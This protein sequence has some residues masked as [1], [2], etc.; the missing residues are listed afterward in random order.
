[1]A[2]PRVRQSQ[3][4]I[5]LI[6]SQEVLKDADDNILHEATEKT[7]ETVDDA[8]KNPE[9]D[10]IKWVDPTW[11][12]PMPNLIQV[13]ESGEYCKYIKKGTK[14]SLF[15]QRKDSDRKEELEG[16]ERIDAGIKQAALDIARGAPVTKIA[17]NE[18]KQE[19]LVGVLDKSRTQHNTQYIK[20]AFNKLELEDN[21]RDNIIS[22]FNQGGKT[23]TAFGFFTNMAN[24]SHQ[25]DFPNRPGV[26]IIEVDKNVTRDNFIF[27]KIDKN[28]VSFSFK[29]Y[30]NKVDAI[31]GSAGRFS[32]KPEKQPILTLT[33]SFNFIWDEEK[34]EMSVDKIEVGI[35]PGEDL[36]SYMEKTN[37]VDKNFPG[38]AEKLANPTM[39][40][41]EEDKNK[42]FDNKFNAF[43]GLAEE[44]IKE[45]KAKIE[46]IDPTGKKQELA[47]ALNSH[48]EHKGNNHKILVKFLATKPQIK[49]TLQ[50]LETIAKVK[51]F[52]TLMGKIDQVDS[53]AVFDM[54]TCKIGPKEIAAAFGDKNTIDQ[55]C[56]AK[57]NFLQK[58]V[59][60][61]LIF[62]GL[63][64]PES[65]H[66]QD[67]FGIASSNK[68][69]LDR[70]AEKVEQGQRGIEEAAL[71]L[72]A[73]KCQDKNLLGKMLKTQDLSK[74]SLIDKMQ[75]ALE[76]QSLG[77]LEIGTEKIL[78]SDKMN[79]DEK[80]EVLKTTLTNAIKIGDKGPLYRILTELGE[81]VNK[82]ESGEEDQPITQIL[83][84]LQNLSVEVYQDKNKET[85]VSEN[86]NQAREK[87]FLQNHSLLSKVDEKV[88]NLYST[89]KNRQ[90]VICTNQDAGSD[91]TKGSDQKN[92]IE[93]ALA[94]EEGRKI[95]L[96]IK[97]A[98]KGHLHP[99]STPTRKSNESARGC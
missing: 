57:K 11:K 10:Q 64:A 86:Q 80:A 53:N 2:A 3:E 13:L 5:G 74:E 78:D 16:Q 87:T 37:F 14:A 54:K 41:S 25:V 1:M 60:A 21:F 88:S 77:F 97:E 44:K 67:C 51:K 91:Q 48:D 85:P 98:E 9:L 35:T 59:D 32:C 23:Y 31:D 7:E 58:I 52:E 45:V 84:K 62:V 73:T 8:S 17:D 29:C 68:H 27:K 92:Q 95:D 30:L 33:N 63:K 39:E 56:F 24:F 36:K 70:L 94:Q 43:L 38:L 83:G 50:E 81:R 69:Y 55:H 20:E 89:A 42:D 72:L 40:I 28:T 71:E 79:V 65:Y 22:E 15:Q 26:N 49:T 19:E 99:D 61:F 6:D 4:K 75:T 76:K 90:Y 18:Y 12:N 66:H 82:I 46:A 47:N 93:R 34:K 96:D